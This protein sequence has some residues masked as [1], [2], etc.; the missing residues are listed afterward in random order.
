MRDGSIAWASLKPQDYVQ[1]TRVGFWF[2]GTLTW[3]KQVVEVAL[4]DMQRLLPDP[5]QRFA[6][7]LDA[8]CG[9][10]RAFHILKRRLKPSRLIG[11]DADP[12]GIASARAEAARR[13]IHVELLEADCASIPLPD[14]S[15]DMVFCHQTL[16]HLVRQEETL[17]EFRRVLKPGGVL[18]LAESTRVYIHSWI[19]RLLFRHPMH[20]QHSAQEYLTMVRRAGFEV[21][22]QQVSYPYLWWSRARDFGLLERWHIQK[23]LP[24]GQREETLVSLVARKPL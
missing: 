2:L 8:G 14:A 20:M 3:E 13:R 11:V 6:T 15:V 19:I 18:M 7:V 16:H 21:G 17:K 10:G 1:E 4:K 12:Q 22:P 9:Q 24:V 23:P 5:E